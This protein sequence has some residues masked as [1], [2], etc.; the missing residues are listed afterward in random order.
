MLLPTFKSACISVDINRSLRVLSLNYNF[1]VYTNF[2]IFTEFCT[3]FLPLEAI[4]FWDSL[5]PAISTDNAEKTKKWQEAHTLTASNAAIYIYIYILTPWCRVLLEKLTRLQLVKKFHAFHGTRRFI[6]ALT[7]V[8]HLSLSWASPIQSIY[9]I[10]INTIFIVI[11]LPF[12]IV[13]YST[14]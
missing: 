1:Q 10:Y 3:T 7:S 6:T 8:R 14:Y 4:Q 11:H 9:T 5:L 2:P 12:P 13:V